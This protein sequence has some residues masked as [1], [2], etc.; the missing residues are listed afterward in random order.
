MKLIEVIADE[1]SVKTVAAIAEKHKARDFRIGLKDRDDSQ[2][3][4]LVVTDD[5]VQEVLDAL[6]GVLGAQSYAKLLVYPID[7][8]LPLRSLQ[9]ERS[10]S[11][12]LS[13]KKRRIAWSQ[14]RNNS[15]CPLQSFCVRLRIGLR[16]H[17]SKRKRKQ[18][19][20]PD[21]G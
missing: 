2:P 12:S 13:P 9:G 18:E 5:K 10:R 19:R 8:S 17:S 3:M 11:Y 16:D 6:Q 1:G 15:T 21:R 20:R 14:Q 7:I 4:R